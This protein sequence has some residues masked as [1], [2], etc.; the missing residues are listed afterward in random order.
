MNGTV[1]LIC[2]LI[3]IEGNWS[4]GSPLNGYV[5]FMIGYL[6]SKQDIKA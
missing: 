3:E 2:T 4:L 5:I 1:P 6:L